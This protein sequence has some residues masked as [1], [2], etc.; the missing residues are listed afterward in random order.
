MMEAKCGVNT[1]HPIAKWMCGG[2]T[3]STHFKI[4]AP[5]GYVLILGMDWLEDNSPMSVHWTQKWMELNIMVEP[6]ICKGYAIVAILSKYN[7]CS[8]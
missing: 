7:Q 2:V 5:G 1:W 4:L 6:F 3:F 8:V